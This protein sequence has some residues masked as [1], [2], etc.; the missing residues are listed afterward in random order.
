MDYGVVFNLLNLSVMPWWAIWIAAP[1]SRIAA[2]FAAHGAVFIGL[3]VLYAALLVTAMA[4]GTGEAAGFD[5]DG[6]RAG[7]TTPVGFLAGWT[8]YLAFD[9]FT[10]A[11]ILR[12]ARRIDVDPRV[13][14]FFT[15]MTGPIG[16]GGF[17]VRRALRLRSLGQIGETDLA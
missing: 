3:S 8:H 14:L 13:F 7:L 4:T 6:V 12:E 15:L 5:F 1:R 17:L 9:L 11:W 2:V 10:G 16:L